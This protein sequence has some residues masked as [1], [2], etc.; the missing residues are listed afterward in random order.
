MIAFLN[1]SYND[2]LKNEALILL[3]VVYVLPFISIKSDFTS[4]VHS[5]PDDE[6]PLMEDDLRAVVGHRRTLTERMNSSKEFLDCCIIK[7]LFHGCRKN[8]LNAEEL[9]LRKTTRC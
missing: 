5:I 6:R 2:K 3:N 9:Q 4:D 7:V 1:Y 8:T